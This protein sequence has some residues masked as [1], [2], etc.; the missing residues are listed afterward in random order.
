MFKI[1]EEKKE[2]SAMYMCIGRYA[3]IDVEYSY[4]SL[5]VYLSFWTQV[6]ILRASDLQNAKKVMRFK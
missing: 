2:L 6:K 3:R 5:R 4:K 1:L